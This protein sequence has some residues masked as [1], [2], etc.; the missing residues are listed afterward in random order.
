LTERVS[1]DSFGQQAIGGTH[2]LFPFAPSL[3]SDGRFVA[4]DSDAVNLVEDD[5]NGTWDVFVRDRQE[6]WTQ[7]VSVDNASFT[8][9][10][11]PLGGNDWS[12]DPAISANGRLVAFTSNAGNFLS[13]YDPL[14]VTGPD[15]FVHD[16]LPERR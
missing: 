12:R 3:S 15:V 4:F 5:T 9:N 16:R 10:G 14:V 8:R 7:R 2:Q 11:V 13:P 6:G 1:V